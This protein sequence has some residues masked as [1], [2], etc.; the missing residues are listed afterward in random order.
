MNWTLV[1]SLIA[2]VLT[3]GVVAVAVQIVS[4]PLDKTDSKD[5]GKKNEN[6]PAV[7]DATKTATSASK[8]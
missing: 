1:L 7:T 2:L 4:P 8:E 3:G 5:T 6:K